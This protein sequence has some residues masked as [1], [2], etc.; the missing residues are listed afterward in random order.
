[1]KFSCHPGLLIALFAFSLSNLFSGD[2]PGP[3]CLPL[4]DGRVLSCM[5]FGDPGGKPVFYFHGLNSSGLEALVL[6]GVARRKGIR[7][8]AI[9]RP[10]IG[11]STLDPDREIVDWVCDVE[12]AAAC[13][14]LGRQRFG[15]IGVSGGASYA[16]ACLVKIPH[17]L[18]RVT[19]VCPFS[20]FDLPGVDNGIEAGNVK[21]VKQ[22]PSLAVSVLNARAKRLSKKPEK[23]LN[24]IF[25][26]WADVDRQ[27]VFASEA[28]ISGWVQNLGN[29]FCQ[30]AEGVVADVGLHGSDWGFQIGNPGCVPVSIWHGASD[31]TAPP[32]MGRYYH[33][34]LD[35]SRFVVVPEEGHLTLL[36][37]CASSILS[38]FSR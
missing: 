5:E 15:I 10:G 23:V 34:Q 18:C 1:M 13:L 11:H 2:G 3:S 36:G 17:R 19:L 9:D 22:L 4:K 31:L 38:E 26:K 7:L 37:N 25:K 21:M 28:S 14:G 20:P 32:S 29:V 30:G 8:I 12:Q 35:G 24:N 6:D 33:G 16:S 27:A